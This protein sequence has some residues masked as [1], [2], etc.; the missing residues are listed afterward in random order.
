MCP[1]YVRTT[2]VII[3]VSKNARTKNVIPMCQKYVRIKKLLLQM[4]H[5]YVRTKIDIKNMC[6]KY[7]RSKKFIM[8]HLEVKKKEMRLTSLIHLAVLYI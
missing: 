2:I 5:K 3:N 6:P 7:V 8:M 4:C 1:K